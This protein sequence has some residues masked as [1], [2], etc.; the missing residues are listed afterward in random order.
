MRRCGQAGASGVMIIAVLVLIMV[1]V[2]AAYLLSRLSSAGDDRV[3]TTKSL[4]AAQA[5]LEQY[6][7]VAMRL[8]CPAD[9]SAN[10]GDEVPSGAT[11]SFPEGTIPWHT[12][13]LRR[14]DGF[15]AWGR[16][17]SYRVY[18]GNKGS[19]T[20][21]G[22]V[23]MVEC[24]AV[25]PSPGGTTS[26]GSAGGLCNS[27][28]NPYLRDTT[29]DQFLSGKG[30]TLND[31]GVNHTDVAYVLISHGL[32][33]LGGWSASGVQLDMPKQDERDNTKDTGPFHIEPFSD[34]DTGATENGHFDDLLAYRT[35]PELVKRIGLAARDWPEVGD[36][37]FSLGAIGDVLP[38]ATAGDL[39][40]S[41]LTFTNG[42]VAVTGFGSGGVAQNI[43]FDTSG[44]G[45]G[46]LGVVG[47][48]SNALTSGTG[49]TGEGLRFGFTQTFRRFAVTLDAFG[50]GVS[51]GTPYSEIVQ[52]TFLN[53]V[54]TVATVTKS[55][56]NPDGG[57]ATFVVD[58]GAN[59]DAVEIRPEETG[60]PGV[61]TSFVV[62][63]IAACPSGSSTC[64]TSLALAPNICP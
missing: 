6:A 20:Q 35:L 26:G 45:A 4:A 27:N 61:H 9:P 51:A 15:D 33:G 55:G 5:A 8:P 7:G 46:G 10:T 47:A 12:I 30:L 2:V 59:F 25:E 49:S 58:A 40:T 39:G 52:L 31:N 38:G 60:V 37:R 63:E 53:G 14:D 44:S 32:T 54:S 43:A 64:T 28:T 36:V 13:G 3:Q 42:G 29:P 41:T 19:L 22:G 11:C 21:A 18:T 57:L 56:C 34:P 1:G 16:K 50:T 23:S 48:G 24:D 62:S 17:I